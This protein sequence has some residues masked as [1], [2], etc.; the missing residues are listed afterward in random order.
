MTSLSEI[1]GYVINL[2]GSDARLASATGQ[3]AQAGLTFER[4]EAVDGRGRSPGE[5]AEYNDAHARRFF[6]SGMNSGEIGCYLSHVAAARAL[7]DSGAP[8]GLIFED[9]FRALENAWDTVAETADFLLRGDLPGWECVNLVRP[10]RLVIRDIATLPSG[11]VL[12]RAY[13]FPVI[14]TALLWSRAG[15][16][17][18]LK[19]ASQPVAPVDHMFRRLMSD[20][21]KGLGYDQAPFTILGV[22]SDIHLASV[23]SGAKN[24]RGKTP[25]WQEKSAEVRRQS[26]AISRAFWNKWTG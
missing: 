17:R 24:K 4:I 14:A 8:A 16:Q 3:F 1:P 26:R 10:P 18:F 25:A 5:F 13:Y 19:E 22:E 12:R 11:R 20:S 2:Q 7:V 15:A 21:G 23:S 6:G 9:D